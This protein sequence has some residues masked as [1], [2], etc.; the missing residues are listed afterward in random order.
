MRTRRTGVSMSDV[1]QIQDCA[2]GYT[3]WHSR[4][5]TTTSTTTLRNLKNLRQRHQHTLIGE[6][7]KSRSG[8]AS[9]SSSR[10]RISPSKVPLGPAFCPLRPGQLAA[11]FPFARLGSCRCLPRFILVLSLCPVIGE[12]Y[13]HDQ[14]A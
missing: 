3:R 6:A 14:S 10:N 1:E 5:A 12:E 11:A 4:P 7:A 13:T 2:S 8:R 9:N